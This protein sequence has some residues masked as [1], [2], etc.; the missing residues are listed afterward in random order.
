MIT[1]AAFLVFRNNGGERE[2]LLAR[3]K[4][5]PYFVFPGGKQE[6]GETIEEALHRELQEELGTQPVDVHKV[7]IVSGHTPD[8]RELEMHLFSGELQGKFQPQSEIEELT[9]M[10]K[11]ST[12]ANAH[13]LT[14]M[15]LDHV[16]PLLTTLKIW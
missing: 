16:F 10:S 3:S 8:G 11:K 7:G 15:A 12:E 4:G 1:K 14:P 6:A 9:W 5:K 2:L 13:I